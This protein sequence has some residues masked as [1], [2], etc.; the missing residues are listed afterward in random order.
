MSLGMYPTAILETVVRVAVA[1]P[2]TGQALIQSFCEMALISST[3][4]RNLNNIGS[5]IEVNSLEVV[6]NSGKYWSQ[7]CTDDVFQQSRVQR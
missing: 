6:K 1:I 4:V 7:P 5:A 3:Y 2:L